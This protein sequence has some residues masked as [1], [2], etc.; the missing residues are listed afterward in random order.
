MTTRQD[1]LLCQEYAASG[2]AHEC[3]FFLGVFF[4]EVGEGFDDAKGFGFVLDDR[5]GSTAGN[6]EDIELGE[7]L[8]RTL[9]ISVGSEGGSL[10]GDSVFFFGGE[11]AFEGFGCCREG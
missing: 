9:E 8:E 5:F 6:D 1:A 2:D 11:D 4:L 10:S 3:A 7:T